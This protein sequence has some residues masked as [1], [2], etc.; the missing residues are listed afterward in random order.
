MNWFFIVANNHGYLHLSDEKTSESVRR[1]FI[2][3][4]DSDNYQYYNV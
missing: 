4:H 1:Y 3:Y 2:F